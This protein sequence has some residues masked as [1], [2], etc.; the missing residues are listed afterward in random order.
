MRA[1]S[2][3]DAGWDALGRTDSSWDPSTRTSTRSL[4][5]RWMR[6]T[7]LRQ[8]EAGAAQVPVYGRQV[9]GEPFS[10]IGSLRCGARGLSNALPQ[11]RVSSQASDLASQ[12]IRVARW[13]SQ[14]IFAIDKQLRRAA[15]LAC[16]Y[17]F[18]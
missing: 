8:I 16:N 2:R 14:S 15:S 11:I 10:S 1:G 7:R 13:I 4:G 12:H 18:P 5:Q 9:L 6:R 3:A 17:R